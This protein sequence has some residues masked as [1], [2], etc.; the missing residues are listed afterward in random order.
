MEWV[1]ADSASGSTVSHQNA[2]LASWLLAG[3]RNTGPSQY[4]SGDLRRAVTE[5][6]L[7]D[8]SGLHSPFPSSLVPSVIGWTLGMVVGEVDAS[9]PVVPSTLLG[10]PELDA[11]YIGLVEHAA[12]LDGTKDQVP[13]LAGSATYIRSAGLAEAMAGDGPANLR[14]A[15][16]KLTLDSRFTAPQ[17]VLTRIQQNWDSR[18]VDHRNV[19]THLRIDQG[20]LTFTAAAAKASTLDHIRLTLEGITQFVCQAVSARLYESRPRDLNGNPWESYLLRELG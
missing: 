20:A 19:L 10:D 9:F 16:E 4:F 13:E 12:S 3:L 7:E 14:Q 18:F 11:A 2:L 8:V 6:A 15:I 5:R 17:E 1:D